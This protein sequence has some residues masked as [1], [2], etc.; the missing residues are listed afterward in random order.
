MGYRTSSHPEDD[1]YR[2]EIYNH[3]LTALK[4]INR[5][6]REAFLLYELEGANIR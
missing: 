1:T 4:A 2:N 3:I 5:N 6:E